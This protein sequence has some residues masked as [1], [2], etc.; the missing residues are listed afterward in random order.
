MP[1]GCPFTHSGM[2]QFREIHKAFVAFGRVNSLPEYYGPKVKND[3]KITPK[4]K[5]TIVGMFIVSMNEENP[6]YEKPTVGNLAILSTER[7]SKLGNSTFSILRAPRSV[8]QWAA[9][10]DSETPIKHIERLVQIYLATLNIDY[11]IRS[12]LDPPFES[13]SEHSTAAQNYGYMDSCR[14]RI[15][16]PNIYALCLPKLLI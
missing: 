3:L 8:A 14:E 4:Q 9:D 11:E 7:Q 10:H 13:T 16:V 15:E 6:F 12:W 2:G 5:P 1:A